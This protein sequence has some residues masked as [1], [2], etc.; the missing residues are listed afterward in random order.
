MKSLSEEKEEEVA[1]EG[2]LEPSQGS[3][4]LFKPRGITNH[5]LWQCIYYIAPTSEKKDWNSSEKIGIYCTKCK[6]TISTSVRNTKAHERHMKSVH[7]DLI[8]EFK[9]KKDKK[10]KSVSKISSFFAKDAKKI[11]S[12]SHADQQ[13]LQLK[14]MY[15]TTADLIQSVKTAFEN[16]ASAK[17]KS[18]FLWSRRLKMVLIL[19]LMICW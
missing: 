11:K 1:Q 12:A 17:L 7:Q 18:I 4:N 5:E 13:S 6:C 3:L 10:R 15:Q 14:N 16:L 2:E 8:D 19:N 9:N